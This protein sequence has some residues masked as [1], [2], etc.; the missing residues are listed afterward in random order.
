MKRWIKG[1][2]SRHVAGFGFGL[3]TAGFE[4]LDVSVAFAFA[5]TVCYAVAMAAI[6]VARE[7]R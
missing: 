5:A 4:R 1:I 7:M 6:E 2:D 3:L